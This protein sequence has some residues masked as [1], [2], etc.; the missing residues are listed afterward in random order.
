MSPANRKRL[1]KK[2]T[3]YVSFKEVGGYITPTE[4]IYMIEKFNIGNHHLESYVKGK[5]K[6][7]ETK[8]DWYYFHL[9]QSDIEK[10]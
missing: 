2:L 1:H 10:I 8:P 7:G 3:Y 6:Q 9:S 4:F 5:I